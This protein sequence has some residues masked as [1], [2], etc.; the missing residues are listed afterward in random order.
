MN[1]RCLYSPIAAGLGLRRAKTISRGIE[2][3]PPL[4]FEPVSRSI[5]STINE[6]ALGT[7]LAQAA[8]RRLEIG[9]DGPL[10]NALKIDREGMRTSGS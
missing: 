10:V 4:L 1:G 2:S 5:G 9:R 3:I 7:E 8:S 6:G